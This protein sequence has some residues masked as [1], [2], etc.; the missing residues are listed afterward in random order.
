MALRAN[1]SNLIETA[2][3]QERYVEYGVNSGTARKDER[4]WSMWCTVCER[5]GTNPMRSAA[6]ARERPE[7]NAHLLACM[8]M[9][10]F[11]T[12]EPRD[13][14]RQYIKPRSALAYPLAIIRIFRRW[15][16]EMPSYKMLQAQMHGLA[17]LY[18]AHHGPH[19]LAPR[20]A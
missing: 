11:A 3:S 4:A 15:G 13:R 16:V 9:H 8:L 19:S 10:A 6:D 5:M 20:R 17:R 7:R 14:T 18:V 1:I 12:C 2:H